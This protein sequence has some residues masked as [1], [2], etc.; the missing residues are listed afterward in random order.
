MMVATVVIDSLSYDRQWRRKD[1]IYRIVSVNKMGG[2]LLE[3]Q[4]F[5]TR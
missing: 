4:Q 3:R 1:D 5:V 2:D